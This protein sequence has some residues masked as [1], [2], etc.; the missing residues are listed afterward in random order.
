MV[1]PLTRAGF[2]FWKWGRGL[3]PKAELVHLPHVLEEALGDQSETTLRGL[4]EETLASA[5]AE[6]LSLE[7]S[8][9]HRRRRD[10]FISLSRTLVKYWSVLKQHLH[11]SRVLDSGDSARSPVSLA[12]A[13]R[14][15]L[16]DRLS[17]REKSSTRSGSVTLKSLFHKS[18]RFLTMKFKSNRTVIP[19]LFPLLFY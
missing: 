12:D 8:A 17:Y 6:G 1:E 5:A 13:T 9:R 19:P 2:H 7:K 4:R 18:Q 11:D 16:P 3:T 15:L 10:G 14:L